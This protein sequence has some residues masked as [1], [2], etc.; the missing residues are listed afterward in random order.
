MIIEARNIPNS[1]FQLHILHNT[2]FIEFSLLTNY[3]IHNIYRFP[4]KFYT[5]YYYD[6]HDFAAAK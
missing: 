3:S 5:A 4:K 1:Q 2:N 6:D